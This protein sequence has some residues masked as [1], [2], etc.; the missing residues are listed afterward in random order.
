MKDA[1]KI[2]T[3]IQAHQIAQELE[4]QNKEPEI[5]YT[6]NIKHGADIPPF[7]SEEQVRDD[8]LKDS[9]PI[10]IKDILTNKITKFD[11]YE[12]CVKYMGINWVTFERM[13]QYRTQRYHS[14]ELVR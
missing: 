10:K 4:K 11:N 12:D 5:R 14:W 3:L 7:R 1:E 13:L 8:V 9:K 2:A 6:C